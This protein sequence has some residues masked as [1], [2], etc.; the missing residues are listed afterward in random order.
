M[1]LA[2]PRR[3]T[4]SK[5]THNYFSAS[6][7]AKVH[8]P[9]DALR[10]ANSSAVF[11]DLHCSRP[12]IRQTQVPKQQPAGY[13]TP[14][15]PPYDF[16]E[17]EEECTIEQTFVMQ[18]GRAKDMQEE[19]RQL[20]EKLTTSKIANADLQEASNA[21]ISKLE[22]ENVDLQD[23]N[24]DLHQQQMNLEEAVTGLQ[25][26]ITA[27][28]RKPM[29]KAPT[30]KSDKDLNDDIYKQRGFQLLQA[31]NAVT[32]ARSETD[33]MKADLIFLENENRQLHDVL[34]Q[35]VQKADA[36]AMDM[37][38]DKT[39]RTIRKLRLARQARQQRKE[40]QSETD[41]ERKVVSSTLELGHHHLKD[42]READLSVGPPAKVNVR[43]IKT[44][45]RIA[46]H[47]ED[48]FQGF[49]LT[50][51]GVGFPA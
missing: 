24:A 17:A 6:V 19:I 36:S 41:A 18:N 30:R 48:V 13:S 8:Q 20:G 14:P 32:A 21:K 27:L 16:H 37:E 11:E 22:A 31:I 28:R 44:R 51:V 43:K 9:Q 46:R 1:R 10:P 42:N 47:V 26:Q 23:T 49:Q 3:N 7:K 34:Q 35:L 38:D 45:S 50:G 5:E 29:R 4:V 39:A 2:S 15:R 12:P 25:R 33:S 40:Q